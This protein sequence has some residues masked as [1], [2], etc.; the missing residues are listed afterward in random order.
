MGLCHRRPLRRVTLTF[1]LLTW[2]NSTLF[3]CRFDPATAVHSFAALVTTREAITHELEPVAVA[4]RAATLV[5]F[6]NLRHQRLGVRFNQF[7]G[8]CD[9][10]CQPR[11]RGVAMDQ[12]QTKDRSG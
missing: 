6:E 7:D 2:A 5:V 3:L 11:H 10:H 8:L 12:G 1:S 4:D 9:C